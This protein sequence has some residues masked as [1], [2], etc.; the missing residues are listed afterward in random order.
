MGVGTA[1][2]QFPAVPRAT[3]VELFVNGGWT[4]ITTDV[5]A[6][7]GITITRGGRDE[8]SRIE[9]SMCQLTL[10]NRTGKYSPRNPNSVFY[11]T[12]GRNTP[13]RVSVGKDADTFTRTVSSG[14]GST[15]QG[16]VWSTFGINGTIAASDYNVGSGAGTHSVPAVNAT[17]ATYLGGQVYGEVDVVVTA[18]MTVA[19]LTGSFLSPANLMLRGADPNNYIL[20]FV[21]I[22]LTTAHYFV[23]LYDTIG[24]SYFSLTGGV[25]Q[26]SG[27]TYAPSTPVK[28]RAYVEGSIVR[29]KVWPVTQPEP[30][31]W[32]TAAVTRITGAGWVGVQSYVD[33]ANTNTK[34]IVFTYDDF[35]VR[36]PRYSGEVSYW[37]QRW[38][39]SGRDVYVPIEAS[40][41]KRRLGQGVA[42]LASAMHTSGIGL[43]VPAVA[44][45]PCEDGPVS[46]QLTAVIGGNAMTVS[47]TTKFASFTGFV[48]SEPLPEL[49]VGT[50]TGRVPSYTST[51]SVCMQFLVHVPSTEPTGSGSAIAQLF[52]SGT[53]ARF[54][55]N[56]RAGGLLQLLIWSSTGTQLYDSA[57]LGFF[58]ASDTLIDNLWMLSLTVTQNGANIDVKLQA[59]QFRSSIS[60][61]WSNTVTGQTVGAATRVVIDPTQ[62][63]KGVSVGHIVVRNENGDVFDQSGGFNAFSGP[64]EIGGV[65]AAQRIFDRGFADGTTIDVWGSIPTSAPVGPRRPLP[66][67]TILEESA[68]A[69]EG[70]LFDSRSVFG[71][72]YRRPVTLY[73]ASPVLVLDYAAGRVAPPLEPVDDD[74][75]TRNDIIAT[76]TD[77][78]SFE[79]FLSSG[80]LSTA[81]P[82]AGGVG[83]YT[84]EV[85]RNVNTDDQLPD[86]A[87]FHLLTGTVDQARYPGITVNLANAN[88]VAAGLDNAVLAVNVG[89]RIVVNNPPTF[90]TVDQISQIVRGY[91]ETLNVF[92]HTITFICAPA[93]PY[94]VIRAGGTGLMTFDSAGSSLASTA[95]TSATSLSVAIAAGHSLWVTG[96]V[97]FDIV[98]EGERVSVTNISGASTPQTFTVVRSVNGV[99]KTHPAGAVVRLFRPALLSLAD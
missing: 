11:G 39:V 89:S 68:E 98:V 3:V 17:R 2:T 32:T 48:C 72:T 83:R 30:Y 31:D 77:G 26:D 12:L 62:V 43:T 59:L 24:G 71:L 28:V 18:S 41:L 27:L 50:W 94:D 69:D 74:Q 33:T 66:V 96:A 67:V 51:G 21:S 37:P 97:T 8:T 54:D 95:T 75:Q 63:M 4:D 5:Y 45:W 22:D 46:T 55:I 85:T 25:N 35:L 76:R 1:A 60:T 34:P 47:G 86:I 19:T 90:S 15:D 52:T 38:D 70:L 91:T 6:R 9:P 49:N 29:A 14:W 99:V 16:S 53:A 13:L 44:Y 36:V 56:Y 64:P 81:D 61:T 80:R 42:P 92:E 79:L 40:G 82:W 58:H 88:V 7:D 84:D 57:I 23:D 93:A 65:T 87:G 73:N 20:V 10:N 78:G